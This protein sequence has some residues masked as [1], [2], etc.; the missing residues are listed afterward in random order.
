MEVETYWQ[1]FKSALSGVLKDSGAD[2]GNIRALGVS[3]QG[4]TLILVDKDGKPLRRAIVWLDNRA[5]QEAERIGGK[6]WA[7][8]GVPDHRTG[9]AGA[10]LARFQ[11]PVDQKARAPRLRT[12][13]PGSC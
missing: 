2:P 8:A 12:R 4:E 10:H 11:D 5:Q 9:E 1:A 6:I 7:S 13:P 3:A